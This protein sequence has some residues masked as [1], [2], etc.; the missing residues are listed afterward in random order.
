LEALLKSIIYLFLFFA[1]LFGSES[2]FAQTPGNFRTYIVTACGGSLP[3]PFVAGHSGNLNTTNAAT[4]ITINTAYTGLT[5]NTN[6]GGGAHNN[7]QLTML[8]NWIIK[9]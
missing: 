5:I 3:V 8:C 7:V 2:A 4:N 9:T 6:S 1:S